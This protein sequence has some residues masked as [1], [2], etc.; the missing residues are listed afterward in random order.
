MKIR[1]NVFTGRTVRHWNR[2]AKDVVQSPSLDVFKKY[3]T[4]HLVLWLIDMV[5]FGQWLEPMTLEVFSNLNDLVISPTIAF[6]L[7]LHYIY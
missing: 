5:V 3:S 2:Q 6:N 1:K 4:R 7:I